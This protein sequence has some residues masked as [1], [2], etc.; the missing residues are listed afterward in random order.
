ISTKPAWCLSD[1]ISTSPGGQTSRLPIR[2]R[3]GPACEAPARLSGYKRLMR[4]AV[5]GSG[6]LGGYFGARLARAGCDV[7]FIARGEHLAAMKA[8]GLR[9]ESQLG[10][11]HL[12]EVDATDDPSS[13]QPVDLVM[14]CVKLWDSEA[15][16]RQ[17]APL[18]G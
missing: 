1:R 3:S 14:F 11:V 6:G 10:D 18:V 8:S 5:M 7:T 17:V 16:A 2:A 15:A 13:L 9:V 4:V 12:P